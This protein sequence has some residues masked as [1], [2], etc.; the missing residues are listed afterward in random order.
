[1]I[2]RAHKYGVECD[3]A[4]QIRA[5]AEARR[6]CSLFNKSS[7]TSNTTNLTENQNVG[8]GDNSLVANESAH[9][10]ILDAGAIEQAFRFAN[11]SFGRVSDLAT[12]SLSFANSSLGLLDKSGQVTDSFNQA[13]SER[14]ASQKLLV[15][16]GIVALLLAA[17]YL[18][19]NKKR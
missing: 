15:V 3:H 11:E 18:Y 8:A 1:M 6:V 4:D 7:S 16:G 12:T 5:R 10:E 9:V 2:R 19:R 13:L 17:A 14:T